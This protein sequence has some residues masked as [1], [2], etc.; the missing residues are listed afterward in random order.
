MFEENG[1]MTSNV[2]PALLSAPL[3]IR[4][5]RLNFAPQITLPDAMPKTRTTK[6]PPISQFHLQNH[7]NFFERKMR[8]NIWKHLDKKYYCFS[9]INNGMDLWKLWGFPF[10]LA[11]QLSSGER[12]SWTRKNLMQHFSS[13]LKYFRL[14]VVRCTAMC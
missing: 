6:K 2:S 5:F 11:P 8:K 3:H 4:F 14:S 7:G 1:P 10:A 13:V 12:E 9:G